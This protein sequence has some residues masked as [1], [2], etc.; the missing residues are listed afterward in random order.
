MNDRPEQKGKDPTPLGAGDRPRTTIGDARPA[1]VPVAQRVLFSDLTI[2]CR[3]GVTDE[4]RAR[5]QRLRFNIVLEIRPE[6]PRADKIKEV[7]DYGPLFAK[8]QSVCNEVEFQLLESLADRIAAACFFDSR[9]LTARVRIEKLDR[10]PDMGAAGC[11]LE[12]RRP[13]P[14]SGPKVT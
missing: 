4:E 13:D 5:P 1:M 2:P 3:I 10:Y 6:P 7:V 9:V 14:G 12:Y 8:I 11:E